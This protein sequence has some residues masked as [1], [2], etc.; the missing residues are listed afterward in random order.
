MTQQIDHKNIEESQVKN[1]RKLKKRVAKIVIIFAIVG[2]VFFLFNSMGFIP[3]FLS[4]Q[5]PVGNAAEIKMADLIE[6][7][8]EL[9][10]IPNLEKVES[11]A[12]GTDA[13]VDAV[14]NDY[15]TK[16]LSE[17]YNVEY[18]GT[19]EIA[20]KSYS[21]VGLL[22]GITAVGIVITNELSEEMDYETVVLYT[23]GNALDY[24]DII[25]WVKDL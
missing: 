11:A 13:T 23:T 6:D 1:S 24:Q 14:I 22:K 25:K 19:V 15:T 10:S 20:G 2:I 9:A 3:M 18:D 7:I 21:F 12:Y 5:E 8:P 16:L 17:G 4:I